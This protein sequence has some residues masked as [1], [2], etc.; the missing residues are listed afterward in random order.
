VS[1]EIDE[2]RK[3]GIK[4]ILVVVAVA[5]AVGVALAWAWAGGDH[6]EPEL[7]HRVLIVGGTPT[8]LVEVVA[9]AGFEATQISWH[10]AQTQCADSQGA[11]DVEAVVEH[12]DEHGYGFVAL[13][14]GDDM[15]FE[16]TILGEVGPE[17]AMA[18]VISIGDLAAESS[19]VQFGG[20]PDQLDYAPGIQR[21]EALRMALYEHADLLALWDEPTSEELTQQVQL[22]KLDEARTLLDRALVRYRAASEAWQREPVEQSEAMLVRGGRVVRETPLSVRVDEQRRVALHYGDQKLRFVSDGGETKA[23]TIDP[24]AE[25][26]VEPDAALGL[27][28]T[29]EGWQRWRFD[30]E[31]P[32]SDG[33]ITAVVHPAFSL[34]GSLMAFGVGGMEW[35]T[36]AGQRGELAMHPTLMPGWSFDTAH[37]VH[38]WL[39]DEVAILAGLYVADVDWIGFVGLADPEGPKLATL[40]LAELRPIADGTRVT[41]EALQPSAAGLYL[42]IGEFSETYDLRFQLIRVELDPLGLRAAMIAIP[43]EPP[44][45]DD[46]VISSAARTLAQLGERTKVV[47]LGVLPSFVPGSLEVAPDGTWLAW[48][49]PGQAG[50]IRAASIVDDALTEPVR[51]GESLTDPQISADS[52]HVLST[53]ER[54]LPELGAFHYPSLVPRPSP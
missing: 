52:Q 5:S 16:P 43:G 15:P 41:I 31:L 4:R 18:A 13:M 49:S 53:V 12:A 33:E 38:A 32:A 51:L 26:I 7:A 37:V 30:G 50:A 19:R 40:P 44:S 17:H 9:E 48:R 3:G 25:W 21:S 47:D 42:V 34:G 10:E 6:S 11:L 29:G 46:A 14:L 28:R 27:L 20:P 54:E 36:V 24:L 22:A 35:S 39:D 2:L 8:D 23:T 45:L 1:E